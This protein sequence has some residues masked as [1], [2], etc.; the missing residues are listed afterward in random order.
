MSVIFNEIVLL[1]KSLEKAILTDSVS[2]FEDHVLKLIATLSF[3]NL[4]RQLSID[5]RYRRLKAKY[6]T[7][8]RR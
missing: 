1:K 2:Y 6:G 3:L 5:N 8:S 4:S 7:Y